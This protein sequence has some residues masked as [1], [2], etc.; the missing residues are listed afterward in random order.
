MKAYREKNKEALRTR[1]KAYREDHSDTI[2]MYMKSY[3]AENREAILEAERAW[4]RAN[5]LAV[6]AKNQKRRTAK[7]SAGPS[8]T[9]SD[10]QRYLDL[11]GERCLAC[12]SDSKLTVDHVV[13]LVKGGS[14]TIENLQGLCQPCNSSKGAKTYDFRSAA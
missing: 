4:M 6:I 9:K 13:P 8:F 1:H 14:N 10:W 12:G 3:R 5:P 2:T 11:F 7:I